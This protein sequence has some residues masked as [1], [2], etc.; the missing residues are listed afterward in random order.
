MIDSRANS[1]PVIDAL[2]GEA[3]LRHVVALA[4]NIGQRPAGHEPEARA[5]TY[6]R[7]ALQEIGITEVKTQPFQAPDSWGYALGTPF[8]LSLAGILLG[9]LG[10]LGRVAG[11]ALGAAGAYLTWRAASGLR[12]PLDRVGTQRPSANLIVRIPSEGRYRRTMVLLAHTDTN[13]HRNSFGPTRK[14]AVPA[15]TT[16]L[17]G[18]QVAGAVAQVVGSGWL[19][20]VAA[21]AQIAGLGGILADEAGPFVDGANDNASAIA[22][23]L[24]I[25]AALQ[26]QPLQHTEV[27]L[28][29]TG[30]EEA[31]LVGTHVLLDEYGD[32]LRSAGFLDFEMVGSGDLAYIADYSGFSHLSGYT[33]DDESVSLVERTAN[34]HP[35]FGVSGK[36]LMMLD[37][38][39]A[40]RR[41]GYRGV[42][43]VGL[44]ADGWPANWHRDTDAIGNIQPESLERAAR[45]GLAMLQTLD[46]DPR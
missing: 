36:P 9:R 14:A 21:A 26:A 12:Q 41:R 5:R 25:G 23:L 16:A 11:A 13:R 31:G 20:G 17:I 2:D 3:L 18:L 29:F 46:A 34:A 38:V 8:A 37:E 42:C 35:H 33:P 27:W 45:F 10:R 4:Y 15:T 7:Q 39:A 40:L 30:A 6:I 43:L 24:G 22:C 1:R 32:Q 28:V 19:S 44:G